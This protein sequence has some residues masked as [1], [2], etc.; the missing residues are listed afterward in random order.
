MSD[1]DSGTD[2]S[3]Y[4]D[5][6]SESEKTYTGSESCTSEESASD[7]D[8]EVSEFSDTASSYAE[9]RTSL[10]SADAKKKKPQW[11]PAFNANLERKSGVNRAEPDSATAP[12]PT[13]KV[14][15]PASARINANIY[16]D[17]TDRQAAAAEKLAKSVNSKR[18]N[19]ANYCS[20]YPQKVLNK[21]FM[22]KKITLNEEQQ[23]DYEELVEKIKS[24]TDP[25]DVPVAIKSK[26]FTNAEQYN[27]NAQKITMPKI[28]T[29]NAEHYLA[30]LKK[31]K[32]KSDIETYNKKWKYKISVFKDSMPEIYKYLRKQM[33]NVDGMPGGIG[34]PS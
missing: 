18:F 10:I 16:A 4:S 26:L 19:L 12:A 13:R 8:D 7:D 3:D 33:V 28:A 24:L 15:D 11:Q 2:I 27:K 25:K 17:L 34:S 20:Q 6:E 21:L 9:S 30:G 31:L 22:S 32:N 29:S 14:L 23:K 1:T 5:A